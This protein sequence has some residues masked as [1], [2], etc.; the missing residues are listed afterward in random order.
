M[1][2]RARILSVNLT[3]RT[4]RLFLIDE[5]LDEE[6]TW[7]RLDPLPAGR[8]GLQEISRPG[9]AIRI[10][11]AFLPGLPLGATSHQLNKTQLVYQVNRCHDGKIF[12]RPATGQERSFNEE[13]MGEA[14]KL[15]GVEALLQGFC[16]EELPRGEGCHFVMSFGSPK[17]FFV[18]CETS[19][20][21]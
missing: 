7:D 13:L 16:Y 6:D 4:A 19:I 8:S 3:R 5:G 14:L 10:R 12:L 11:L 1:Y 2:T 9:L 18:V 15:G 21:R 17:L 20:D